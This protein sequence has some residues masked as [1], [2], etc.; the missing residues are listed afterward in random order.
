M[1]LEVLN[2]FLMSRTESSEI[3]VKIHVLQEI[4][5]LQWVAEEIK[6]LISVVFPMSRHFSKWLIIMLKIVR[7]VSIESM[8]VIYFS[9]IGT[10]NITN[11]ICPKYKCLT[12]LLLWFQV[13]CKKSFIFI[14]SQNPLD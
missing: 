6:N 1:S 7:D 13:D 8:N 12:V 10:Q 5:G 11:Y 14:W 4:L 9:K 2:R 3:W